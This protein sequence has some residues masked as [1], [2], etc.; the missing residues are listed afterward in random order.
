[1]HDKC[2]LKIHGKKGFVVLITLVFCF[3]NGH[4]SL[5]HWSEYPPL[6]TYQ[7]VEH[8]FTCK[9]CDRCNHGLLAWVITYQEVEHSFT[10][11]ARVRHVTT[12]PD[13]TTMMVEPRPRCKST[14]RFFEQ[15][16]PSKC[17]CNSTLISPTGIIFFG[18]HFVLGGKWTNKPLPS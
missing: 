11:E 18:C 17:K 14:G 12:W 7:K 13:I 10:C 5:L 9:A 8:N 6:I 1:M 3:S 15:A 2:M 16:N 4:D